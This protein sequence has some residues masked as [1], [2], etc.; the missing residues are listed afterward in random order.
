VVDTSRTSN[1]GSGAL[2]AT[3]KKYIYN[4]LIINNT[5]SRAPAAQR[6]A[7]WSSIPMWKSKENP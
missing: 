5:N 7:K 1:G 2:K 3:T 6:T 4:K